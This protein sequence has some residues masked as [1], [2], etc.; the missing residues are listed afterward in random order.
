MPVAESGVRLAGN[1]IP[2]GPTNAVKSGANAKKFPGLRELASKSF[3][4]I[5]AGRPDKSLVVSS[6][7][8]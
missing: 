1:D 8:P 2:H 4:G 7:G 6:T 5:F 3:T